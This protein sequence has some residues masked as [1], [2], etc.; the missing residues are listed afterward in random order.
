MIFQHCPYLLSWNIYFDILTD[1]KSEKGRH[2]RLHFLSHC[3]Q[4][5]FKNYENSRVNA[6]NKIKPKLHENCCYFENGW[7]KNFF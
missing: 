6:H 7:A 1:S 5:D 4:I 3:I 2:S